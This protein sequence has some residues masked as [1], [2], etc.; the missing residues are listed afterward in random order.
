MSTASCATDGLRSLV[1]RTVLCSGVDSR[2]RRCWLGASKL[3]RSRPTLSQAL[4]ATSSGYLEWGGQ[5]DTSGWQA[6]RRAGAGVEI[7]VGVGNMYSDLRACTT[8]RV[9]GVFCSDC[10]A[11]DA[12]PLA[13]DG[14]FGAET[15]AGNGL[16]EQALAG[17]GAPVVLAKVRL[18]MAE[19]LLD[20]DEAEPAIA[21][22]R[23]GE[24]GMARRSRVM[25]EV[26]GSC[27]EGP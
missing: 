14:G 6:A 16:E 21:N 3:P 11:S 5:L 23:R 2:P 20:D 18:A 1:R 24:V 8:A 7:E 25:R 17:W 9:K 13:G 26:I 4:S 12:I 27:Q 15:V 19:L 22:R 10:A